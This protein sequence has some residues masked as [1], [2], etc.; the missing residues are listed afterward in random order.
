MCNLHWCYSFCTDVTLFALVLHL[1]CTALSQS[2]SSNFLICII[3]KLI[4]CNQSILHQQNKNK[5]R[6]LHACLFK[7][8]HVQH[9]L[10]R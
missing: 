4:I 1:N 2:E 7:L 5:M 8:D 9:S 10:R 3:I 6:A